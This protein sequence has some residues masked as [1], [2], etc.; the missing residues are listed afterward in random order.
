MK[1]NGNYTVINPQIIQFKGGL[2][3]NGATRLPEKTPEIICNFEVD[4]SVRVPDDAVT[5][6]IPEFFIDCIIAFIK[7]KCQ[8]AA[9]SELDAMPECKDVDVLEKYEHLKSIADEY[10]FKY[11][12]GE[13]VKES[14]GTRKVRFFEYKSELITSLVTEYESVRKDNDIARIGKCAIHEE[15]KALHIEFQTRIEKKNQK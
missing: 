4:L 8:G 5:A 6:D 15:L 11:K 9:R 13:A 7:V 2:K 1:T 14:D 10:T 3:P 12:W